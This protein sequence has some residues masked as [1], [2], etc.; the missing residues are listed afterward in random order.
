M[1]V[2]QN[3]KCFCEELYDT[4]EQGKFLSANDGLQVH[5]NIFIHWLCFPP[6]RF[7]ATFYR[8]AETKPWVGAVH[9]A[10]V[11][12]LPVWRTKQRD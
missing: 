12:E 8:Q 3:K 10:I 11:H 1:C 4:S 2:D 7:F 9:I 6:F 5:V